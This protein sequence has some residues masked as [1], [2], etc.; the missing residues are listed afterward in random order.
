VSGKYLAP[1]AESSAELR[2]QGSVFLASLRPVASEAEAKSS[3]AA[4]AALYA[5]ATHHCWA[6]RLG[7]EPARERAVDGGEPRGTAG[8]PILRALRGAGL[9]D[10]L[11]VVS[12]WF[13]GVKLGKGGLA[14]AY[15]G[16]AQAAIAATPTVERAPTVEIEVEAAYEL[17]GA[18]KRLVRPP[19]IE[20]L[21]EDYGATARLVL[22]AW[23]EREAE[24]RSA[25][26]ELLPRVAVDGRVD[27]R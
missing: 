26:A 19:Q 13:G 8:P 7:P 25:L 2:E 23:R 11:V 14:R 15:A 27:G 21:A 9:S 12:R 22:R 20:L 18:V 3:L 17:V 5:D 10:V 24:L 6:S 16:A 1:A 4:V